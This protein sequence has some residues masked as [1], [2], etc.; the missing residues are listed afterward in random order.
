M[1][2]LVGFLMLSLLVI[3]FGV[4]CR[5]GDSDI[6]QSDTPVVVL[7][8]TGRPE[9]RVRVELARTAAERARGLMFRE[10]LE[11]DAGM[12]FIYEQEENLIFWMKNTLIPLDMIFISKEFRV[13]GIVENAAPQT[14][15]V[16]S[17]DQPAQFVLEVNAGF[18]AANGIGPGT[19]VEFVGI[20]QDG[21]GQ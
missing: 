6:P 2:I 16:R 4:G 3:G 17:I 12:L 18:A 10:R 20:D 5:S 19:E 11:P 9:V 7:R 8:P 14:E 1:R 13:A 21:A 15:T